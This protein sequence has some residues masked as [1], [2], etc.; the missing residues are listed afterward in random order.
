MKE[1]SRFKVAANVRIP[2]LTQK[3]RSSPVA[4][5]FS[6]GLIVA[7]PGALAA[8]KKFGVR[9]LTLLQR[10]ISGDW[11]HLCYRDIHRTSLA[12]VNNNRLRSSYAID[13]GKL[14]DPQGERVWII[15]EWDHSVTTILLPSEE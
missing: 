1:K 13:G 14:D 3:E 8:L 5:L 2:Q 9:P 11:G 6:L 15:T 12:L 7:T 4:P 10:H